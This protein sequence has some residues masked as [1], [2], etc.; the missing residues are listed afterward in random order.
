MTELVCFR[1][2]V[3]GTDDEEGA[4]AVVQ[5]QLQIMNFVCLQKKHKIVQKSACDREC[6]RAIIIATEG[7]PLECVLAV[8]GHNG[9]FDSESGLLWSTVV[10]E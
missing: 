10:S 1:F 4:S 6:F 7:Y 8:A 2:R 5:K 3:V 9:G